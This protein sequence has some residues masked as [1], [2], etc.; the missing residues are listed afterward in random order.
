MSDEISSSS[1]QRRLSLA[2]R[3]E[4]RAAVRW[5]G[6]PLV[7]ACLGALGCMSVGCA[8]WLFGSEDNATGQG[9]DELEPC[10]GNH[11]ACMAH[12]I[13]LAEQGK[14]GEAALTFRAL[15]VR[16]DGDACVRQGSIVRDLEPG[17]VGDL[18]TGL[19]A[20]ASLLRRGCDLGSPNGCFLYASM[21]EYGHVFDPPWPSP[22]TPD[23]RYAFFRRGCEL[24]FPPSCF[25]LGQI[26]H[27]GRGVTVDPTR[28]REAY[29]RSCDADFQQACVSLSVLEREL[30]GGGGEAGLDARMRQLN[31]KACALGGA[32]GCA[33]V[34]V[35]EH[36]AGAPR[37]RVEGHLRRACELGDTSSCEAVEGWSQGAPLS[38]ALR[39]ERPLVQ[40]VLDADE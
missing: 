15:C 12:G 30:P 27:E 1:E 24:E 23:E 13:Q 33:N 31:E 25:S 2:G 32:Y 8:G 26:L 20:E 40:E 37:T 6:W 21:F 5:S 10:G 35:L 4:Y 14:L 38:L 9:D 16:G 39:A 29:E 36:A 3:E 18:E 22:G 28:A 34:A 19:D 11:D 17:A 7:V